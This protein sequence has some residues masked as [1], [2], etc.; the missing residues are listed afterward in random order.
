MRVF[1]EIVLL[2]LVACS[3]SSTD[4]SEDSDTQDSGDPAGV[5]CPEEGNGRLQLDPLCV[6]GACGGSDLVDVVAFLGEPDSCVP[7]DEG[8]DENS[9]HICSW[10]SGIS[11]EFLPDEG[12]LY[13]KYME[14]YDQ[15][16]IMEPPWDGS[17]AEGTI[18]MDADVGFAEVS[19][20]A[21]LGLGASRGCFEGALGEGRARDDG[22][23]WWETG[24]GEAIIQGV[25]AW[26]EEGVATRM[27]LDWSYYE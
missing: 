14:F 19:I 22:G 17:T 13:S 21:G 11:M 18:I 27:V 8:G 7:R 9:W 4:T 10:A 12:D 26:F 20:P 5:D 3:G 25:G 1:R 2:V 24:Y 6:D 23:T 15:E 16:I